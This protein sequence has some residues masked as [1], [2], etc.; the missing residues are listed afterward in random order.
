MNFYSQ[1]DTFFILLNKLLYFISNFYAFYLFYKLDRTK[2]LLF[3]FYLSIYNLIKS[4]SL[5]ALDWA[6]FANYSHD[7]EFYKF[8]FSY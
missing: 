1:G 5:Y 2:N 7:F 3:Y 6:C 8:F 4:F